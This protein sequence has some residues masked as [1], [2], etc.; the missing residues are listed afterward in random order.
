MSTES[1][2]GRCPACTATIPACGLL[3]TYRRGG[4]EAVFAECQDCNSV[5]RPVE[6]A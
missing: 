4:T 1:T 2:L 6:G 3:I 5:V